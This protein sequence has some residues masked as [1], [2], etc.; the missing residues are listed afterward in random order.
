MLRNG[1]EEPALDS[2]RNELDGLLVPSLD[3]AIAVV[4]RQGALAAE[5]TA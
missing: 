2:E 4:E 1:R 5:V 3:S